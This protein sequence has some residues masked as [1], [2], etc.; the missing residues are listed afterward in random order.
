[1]QGGMGEID[2]YSGRYIL[3]VCV[4][5]N[6]TPPEQDPTGQPLQRVMINSDV[7]VVIAVFI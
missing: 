7:Y 3:C 4:V 6:R 1:V 2:V 5:S